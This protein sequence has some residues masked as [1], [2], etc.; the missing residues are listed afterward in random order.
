MLIE[1]GSI[2]KISI[3]LKATLTLNIMWPTLQTMFP[4]ML[5]NIIQ[6]QLVFSGT[7]YIWIIN[8][9]L[10]RKKNLLVVFMAYSEPKT[11]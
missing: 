5:P 10:V 6:I 11:V 8:T 3:I 7:W 9:L 1:R 4:P 2:R